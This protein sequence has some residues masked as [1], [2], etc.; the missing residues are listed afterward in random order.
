[1]NQ[2]RDKEWR[3]IFLRSWFMNVVAEQEMKT[4]EED[5]AADQ[6]EGTLK[7]TWAAEL[8]DCLKLAERVSRRNFK[9][10]LIVALSQTLSVWSIE[11][12]KFF[13]K[14]HVKIF[15]GSRFS[16]SQHTRRMTLGCRMRDLLT[17]LLSISDRAI[18]S[19][20]LRDDKIRFLSHGTHHYKV[21]FSLLS[22]FMS[23]SSW[24]NIT[25]AMTFAWIKKRKL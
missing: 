15:A 18:N 6:A 14:L 19:H 21:R 23:E 22:H 11:T 8:K 7:K 3:R 20:S 16:G 2:L 17:H 24:I 9:T 5:A 13:S 25:L 10:T 4:L 1:M 12:G